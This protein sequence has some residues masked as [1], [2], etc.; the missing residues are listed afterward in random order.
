MATLP[1]GN[2]Y[3]DALL[4]ESASNL[5]GLAHSLADYME[6]IWAEAREANK[7]SD[8][9]AQHPVVRLMLWQMTFL[10]FGHNPHADGW[11]SDYSKAYA[12]CQAK[13]EQ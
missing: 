10:S 2:I 11:D 1:A 7:G 12:E 5:S 9:V 6:E 8:Y 3:Q 4:A 13:A